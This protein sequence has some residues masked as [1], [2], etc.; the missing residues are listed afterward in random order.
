MNIAIVGSYVTLP[1]ECLYLEIQRAWEGYKN[2]LCA[3][4][5]ANYFL[6]VGKNPGTSPLKSLHE[7]SC[8]RILS[9]RVCRPLIL[10]D[11]SLGFVPSIKSQGLNLV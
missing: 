3:S 10:K 7:G 8:L 11:K 4:S 1:A 9:S 6:K 5:T 2:K